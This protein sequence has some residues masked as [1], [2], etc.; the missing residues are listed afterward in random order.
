MIRLVGNL[1]Y[2]YRDAGCTLLTGLQPVQHP[3][4]NPSRPR[5]FCAWP[6]G[7]TSPGHGT[8][9]TETNATLRNT[10]RSGR[11]PGRVRRLGDAGPL[12]QYRQGTPRRARRRRP[13]RHLAYGG[14]SLRGAGREK[15]PQQ[16][17]DQRPLAARAGARSILAAV[18]G[19]RRRDRRPVRLSAWR[20]SLPARR[21]RLSGGGRL[22]VDPRPAQHALQVTRAR[23]D[24]RLR[25]PRCDGVA[26]ANVRRDS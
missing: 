11:P 25:R 13:V 7:Y 15:V 10:R 12:H 5:L 22:D 2:N 19:Q 20:D 21:Q 26:G 8:T 23:D 1:S 6:S 14:I 3:K 18:P 16:A 4:T 17:A 9:R 24:R